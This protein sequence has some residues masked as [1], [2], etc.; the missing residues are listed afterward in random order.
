MS[1][2]HL[3]DETTIYQIQVSII[4]IYSYYYLESINLSE[5][6]GGSLSVPRLILCTQAPV[7]RARWLHRHTRL[8]GA[9]SQLA[10]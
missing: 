1:S 7:K 9:D 10:G 3:T 5:S 4:M 6:A 2:L 8:G